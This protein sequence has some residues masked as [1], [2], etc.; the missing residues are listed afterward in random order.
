MR[1]YLVLAGGVGAASF[2]ATFIRLAQGAGMSSLS[3]AAIRLLLVTLLYTPL[4]LRRGGGVLERLTRREWG[5]I[6]LAGVFLAFHFTTFITALEYTAVLTSLVLSSTTPLYAAFLGW[7]V[8]QERVRPRVLFGVVLA[9]AGIVLVGMGGNTGT[10]STRPAPLLGGALAIASA[11][12]LASYFTVGRFIRGKLDWLTYSWL[13]F[14]FAALTMLVLLPVTGNSVFGYTLE[15]YQWVLLVT[16]FAQVIGHTS[17]NFALGQLSATLVSLVMMVVPVGAAIV[18]ALILG[19]I[20][21][22]AAVIGS[23]VVLSG[24]ALANLS[25]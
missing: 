20:P 2:A 16:L 23:G 17:F 15:A 12:L 13:V 8:L 10:P 19:E 4:A 6:A 9:L 1:A 25:S 3:I 7:V 21:N 24:V 22:T 14:A 18:A 11:V 5:F